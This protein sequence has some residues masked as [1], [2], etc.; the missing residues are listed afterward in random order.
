MSNPRT[1]SA[2]PLISFV[3]PV[4]NAAPY[5][6]QALR[7]LR[8]QTYSNLEILCLND[9]STDTSLAILEQHASE[10]DR[11]LVVDKPNEGYGATCN[12]GINEAHGEWIGILEPDDWLLPDAVEAMMDTAQ[13][14]A[15]IGSDADADR[16]AVPDIVK[17]PY[18]RVLFADT[19][20]QALVHCYYRGTPAPTGAKQL[21]NGWLAQGEPAVASCTTLME[22]HPSIWS[23]LYRADFLREHGIRFLPIPGAGW[24]DNP[25]LVE[26]MAAARSIAYLDEPFYCYR[27]ETPAHFDSTIRNQPTLVFDRWND[28]AD[29][30]ERHAGLDTRVMQA[31]YHRGFNNRD[32]AA[33]ILGEESPVTIEE[34]A[35]MFARMQPELVLGDPAL[36]PVQKALFATTRGIDYRPS[37]PET[38]AFKVRSL[39]QQLHNVRTVGLQSAR[40]IARLH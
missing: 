37:L 4:F 1:S 29:V 40:A 17:T 19:P 15:R 27:E 31:H 24:A 8:E 34:T 14:A 3:V 33:A 22:Y 38:L 21:S 2:K 25:F 9:G 26:T 20:E 32:K 6:S 23:A 30:L 11:V 10:D 36:S 5:L 39:R 13:E 12:R 35:R 28:G 18:W 16:A 7:S